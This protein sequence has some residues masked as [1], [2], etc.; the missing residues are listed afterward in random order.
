[1]STLLSSV[2][3]ILSG[4]GGSLVTNIFNLF[5]TKQ[6]HK[7][8]LALIEAR[9]KEMTRESELAIQKITV[10]ADISK[11]LAAADAF[12]TSLTTGNQPLVEASMILRLLDIKWLAWLGGILIFF[13]GVVDVLRSVMRPALTIALFIITASIV[14]QHVLIIK[15]SQAVLSATDII[16]LIDSILYMTFT[17]VGWWF[18]DRT[19]G[20]F[21]MRK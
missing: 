1:M 12:K 9:I 17:A 3:G 11:E 2:L 18:G 4:V 15:S 16:S 20:K 8:E 21:A 5:T 6:A 10:E 19:I 13:M 7:H 14:A